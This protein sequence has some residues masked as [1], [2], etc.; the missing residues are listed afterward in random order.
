M[1][2]ELAARVRA[3]FPGAYDDLDDAALERAILAKYPDYADLAQPKADFRTETL[4]SESPN[5]MDSALSVAGDLGTGVL[6]GAGQT[7][8][9]LGRAVHMIPGVTSAV[10]ALSAPFFPDT[11]GPS[12]D[13]SFGAMDATLKPSNLTQSIGKGAEQLGE[14]FIPGGMVQRASKGLGIAGRAGL[15]ALAG[16]G[17]AAAQGGSPLDIGLSGALAGAPTALAPFGKRLT[18]SIAERLQASAA[19]RVTEGLGATTKRLKNEASRIAPEFAERGL[20]G[21][22]EALSEKAAEQTGTIGRDIG[23]AIGGEIGQSRRAT[24]PI[25][26]ALEAAKTKLTT[27]KVGAQTGRRTAADVLA[28]VKGEA[29]HIV[30]DKPQY[31]ALS[32]LQDVV[33]EYG[34][35]MSVEQVNTLKKIYARVTSRA[36][37]YNEKAG[38]I[39][40]T[41]PEAAKTFATILREEENGV[42]ALAKLNK[43]FRFWKGLE[44]VTKA[45]VARRTSQGKG[46]TAA[47]APVI[48]AATGAA[49]GDSIM[50]RTQNAVLGGLAARNITKALQS[51][52]WKFVRAKYATKIA[53]ALAAN[54][55]EQLG[56]IVGKVL[57]A[58]AAHAF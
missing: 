16:S 48:G 57:A 34:D 42:E 51:P 18:A 28:S 21:S 55:A 14:F 46:L 5:F 44:N 37:G 23:A 31:D 12:A 11:A 32:K 58:E 56:Q 9:N 6:K 13:A 53:H 52:Q 3:K 8:T 30:V 15:E 10:N 43:E 40:N 29:E 36:G 4:A 22:V 33:R 20:T 50:D 39:L 19:K 17:V 25:I 38:E 24:A 35:E 45:T 49:S 41:A 54:D 47:M 2:S 1:P 7:A 26:D 27:T